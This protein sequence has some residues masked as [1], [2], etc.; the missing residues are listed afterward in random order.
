MVSEPLV[1][2][3]VTKTTSKGTSKS[4]SKGYKLFQK[5]DYTVSEY[6]APGGAQLPTYIKILEIPVVANKYNC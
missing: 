2:L 5:A 4:Y 3:V 1:P 6:V